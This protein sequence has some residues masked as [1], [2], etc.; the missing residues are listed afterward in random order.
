M[1]AFMKNKQTGKFDVIGLSSEVVIG[2]VAVTK[3]DGTKKTVY[4]YDVSKPFVGK[5][6]ANKGKNCAIGKVGRRD[7]NGNTGRRIRTPDGTLINE[8]D[9]CELCG[10][11]KYT[12]GHC[13]GW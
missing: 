1:S 8:D 13:I 3:K 9:A 2:D 10:H 12:C 5:Y 7:S 11:D 4:I 6:G